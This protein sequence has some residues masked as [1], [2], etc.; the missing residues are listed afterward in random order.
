MSRHETDGVDAELRRL[1]HGRR[2]A[3]IAALLLVIGVLVCAWVVRGPSDTYRDVSAPV[4]A[5][6]LAVLVTVLWRGRVPLPT[7]E[8]VLLFVL[9]AMPVTRQ[10]WLYHMAGPVTENWLRLVGNNYWATSGVLVMIFTIAD[11][12]RAVIAGAGIVLASVLIAVLGV[13]AGISRGEV[14]AGTIPYIAGAL[15]FLGLFL[16]LMSAATVMRHEWQT[17]LNRVAQYSRWA[18]TDML[19]G[20]ASRRAASES[21]ARHCAAAAR[22]DLGLSVILGDLDGFKKVN[23]TAGHAM[24][25]IVLAGVAEKLRT[26]AREADVVARWGGEEFL[27]IA[28]DTDLEGARQLAERCRSAIE[29]TPVAGI[30]TTMTLGVAQYVKG[31][32]PQS[33]LARADANLYLGKAASRN[34]VEA[35][36]DPPA[37]S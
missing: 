6:V 22:H 10:I 24:G 23:D 34:R 1:A 29:S 31:D 15:L 25:D 32:N 19:T 20:L 9:A 35:G 3:Y 11:R 17:A 2:R 16:V 33:L 36:A 28:P 8:R 18:M 4:F 13:G 30:R 27:I 14:P 21:L 5:V 12:R 26:T 37:R 7:V